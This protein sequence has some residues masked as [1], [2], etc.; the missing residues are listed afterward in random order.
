MPLA[1]SFR[2]MYLSP[3]PEHSGTELVLA[4]EYL[5]IPVPDWLDAG[6]SDI[7][8]FKKAVIGDGER[9]TQCMSK[10]VVESGTPWYFCYMILKSYVNARMTE[11]WRIVSPASAF[12]PVVSCL[13]L[14]SAFQHQGSFRC[15]W[16][17]IS[18]ALPSYGCKLTVS[19]FQYN[20]ICTSLITEVLSFKLILLIAS[21][22]SHKIAN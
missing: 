15:R 8:A 22:S 17:R 9:E 5:F 21:L 6:Q 4:S 7:P 10:Q 12:L 20:F 18:P 3:V 16:S 19:T 11:C 13:S 14:A 2:I 1:S